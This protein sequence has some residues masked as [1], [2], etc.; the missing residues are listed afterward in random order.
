MQILG[1]RI[2]NAQQ[3]STQTQ[4]QYW[5]THAQTL[6]VTASAC[7]VWGYGMINHTRYRWPHWGEK[8]RRGK[9]SS[10]SA[11]HPSRIFS[12]L[13]LYAFIALCPHWSPLTPTPLPLC[14]VRDLRVAFRDMPSSRGV[15][16]TGINDIGSIYSLSWNAQTN[17]CTQVIS[18]S[19]I[20]SK[21]VSPH[22]SNMLKSN[23]QI[24]EHKCETR[25]HCI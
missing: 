18:P 24:C 21:D 19:L 8:G 1:E 11:Q 13:S 7:H 22:I 12:L 20:R 15:D 16:M 4:V 3:K 5:H 9:L 14:S 6:S 2:K 10:L 23:L 25:E 17:P